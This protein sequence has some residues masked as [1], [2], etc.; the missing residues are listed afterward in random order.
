M[1]AMRQ[2][3]LFNA[4][5]TGAGRRDDAIYRALWEA[6]V[7]HKLPP[8]ARLPEDALASAFKISRTGIRRVL[9]RLALERL[10]TLVPNRGA[11]ISHPS[12]TEAHD[13]F[14]ARRMLESSAMISVVERHTAKDLVR[15]R[16]LTEAERQALTQ[17]RRSEAIRLSGQFHTGLVALTGNESLLD[18]ISQ[19]VSRS[20]LIIA[21][22]GDSRHTGCTCSHDEL[23]A[24]VESRDPVAASQWM[25]AHLEEIVS[26]LDFTQDTVAEP[27][28]ERLFAAS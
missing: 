18:F 10:V 14:D 8:G 7:E 22:Y 13:V 23:L 16:Q 2:F 5:M 24:L 28:F 25:S 4:S 21:V 12:P 1:S 26:G 11:Q 6:I 17:R 9:Q 3:H 20:S 15:L 19:L 27:D